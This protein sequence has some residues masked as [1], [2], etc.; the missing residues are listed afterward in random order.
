[1]QAFAPSSLQQDFSHTTR[2]LKLLGKPQDATWLRYLDP[3]NKKSPGADHHWSGSRQDLEKLQKRQ[4]RGLN[5]YLI[6][7]NGTTATA[8]SGNQNDADIADIPALFVEWNNKP[9]EWQISDAR[10]DRQAL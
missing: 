5:A 7:G 4:S 10:I 9:I 3:L 2:F 8:K 6:I 1:M